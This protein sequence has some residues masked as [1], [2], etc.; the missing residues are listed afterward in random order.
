MGDLVV[1]TAEVNSGYR[2]Q[3]LLLLLSMVE[4]LFLNCWGDLKFHM[5]DGVVKFK[6]NG[7]RNNSFIGPRYI[8]RSGGGVISVIGVTFFIF[9]TF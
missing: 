3:L 2:V 8:H 6:F 4:G 1:K 5:V 9:A 7:S